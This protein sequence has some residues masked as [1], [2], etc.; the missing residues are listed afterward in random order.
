M[1]TVLTPLPKLSFLVLVPGILTVDRSTAP[2][3]CPSVDSLVDD[4]ALPAL[5]TIT[6]PL[7]RGDGRW[8]GVG[9]GSAAVD[10]PGSGVILASGLVFGL[11][12]NDVRLAFPSGRTNRS[13]R[14]ASRPLVEPPAPKLDG[15]VK[16][17]MPPPVSALAICRGGN[18][19]IDILAVGPPMSDVTPDRLSLS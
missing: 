1:L 7:V 9:K 10:V 11:L 17:T 12:D 18:L 19:G 13:A 2:A 14:G 5:P 4:P 15:P 16:A 6:S 3:R 8:P